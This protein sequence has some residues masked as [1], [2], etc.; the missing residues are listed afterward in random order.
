MRAH[1][2]DGVE[3]EDGLTAEALRAEGLIYQRLRVEDFRGPL[4]VLKRERGYVHEDEVQ[5]RPTTPGLDAICAKFAEEHLHD[6]DEVRFILE[7][8]GI[9]DVRSGSDRYMRVVVETSD[10]LV[11][12]AQRY[13]RFL[14]T[15]SRT[16]RAVRLFKDPSGWVPRYRAPRGHA[17]ST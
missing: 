13:H 3:G 1:W 7:G 9:F 14:L 12:P 16:V 11:V 4:D 8:E 17:A 5:I 6:E 15:E 10:L 2:L